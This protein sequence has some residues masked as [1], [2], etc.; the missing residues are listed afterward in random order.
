M[1]YP[2]AIDD[3]VNDFDPEEIVDIDQ[4]D[5]VKPVRAILS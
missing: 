3:D 2:S 1:L 4:H 5:T